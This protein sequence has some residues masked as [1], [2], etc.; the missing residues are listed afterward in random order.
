MRS[1]IP[2]GNSIGFSITL[3]SEEDLA[4]PLPADLMLVRMTYSSVTRWLIG[5]DL[6]RHADGQDESH[7]LDVLQEIVDTGLTP[8]DRK[9][10]LFHG[11]WKGSIDPV[12]KQ[13]AY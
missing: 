13:F 4:F 1:H 2:H 7:F 3:V 10:A 9:L 12:F 6:K 8:A 5:T 11:A